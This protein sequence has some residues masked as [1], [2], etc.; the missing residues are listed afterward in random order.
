MSNNTAGMLRRTL[1]SLET[2]HQVA[3]ALGELLMSG[4]WLALEGSLGAG[5]T[6][7]TQ[8][9]VEGVNPGEGEYVA[10]PTYAVCHVYE[11]E[12]EVYHY[13]LYRL[14]SEDDLESVGFY[15]TPDEAV[16]VLEWAS[17][18]ASVLQRVDLLITLT[19]GIG[20]IREFTMEA[21][22]PRGEKRLAAMRA[23]ALGS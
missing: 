11:G 19:R 9:L 20:D 10:S 21:K 22:S 8:G 6:T 18:V 14:V 15:D 13:D 2:T 4:D 3:E 17:N 23:L 1:P 7:F 5:K 16:V 12:P